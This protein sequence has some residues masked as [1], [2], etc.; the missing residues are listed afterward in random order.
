MSTTPTILFCLSWLFALSL[1][2]DGERFK[3]YIFTTHKKAVPGVPTS[4][5]QFYGV[6]FDHPQNLPTA[7]IHYSYPDDGWT[8]YHLPLYDITKRK[9]GMVEDCLNTDNWLI[10]STGAVYTQRVS[11]LKVKGVGTLVI[12]G[13][14]GY[15]RDEGGLK[16][17][18][19]SIEPILMG[20]TPL[21]PAEVIPRLNTGVFKH[22]KGFCHVKAL[23]DILQ[24]SDYARGTDP[25]QYN[26]MYWDCRLEK[27]K[28]E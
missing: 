4:R 3:R 18:N 21:W 28:D 7:D 26:R 9:V 27:S 12:G 15:I 17:L 16:T 1:S 5:P 6:S 20:T 23:M 2:D 13:G 22:L 11:T 19:P 24:W 25:L 14:T 8:C 10:I